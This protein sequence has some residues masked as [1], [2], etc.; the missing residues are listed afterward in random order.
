MIGKKIVT[1]VEMIV[2]KN[3]IPDIGDYIEIIENYANCKLTVTKINSIETHPILRL[4]ESKTPMTFKVVVEA[5][6]VPA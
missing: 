2:E 5:D 4:N 6:I 1:T 3:E